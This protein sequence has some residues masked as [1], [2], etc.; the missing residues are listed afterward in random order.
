M[1]IVFI[2]SIL[3]ILLPFG[4]LAKGDVHAN[5]VLVEHFS[6]MDERDDS[7]LTFCVNLEEEDE[8]MDCEFC[9]E[10][11]AI[12]LVSTPINICRLDSYSYG[13]LGVLDLPPEK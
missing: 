6:S 8:K 5:K 13:L 2:W 3:M 9:L 1:R 4:S 12:S 7:N 10:I 11:R